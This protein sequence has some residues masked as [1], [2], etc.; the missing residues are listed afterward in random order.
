[1]KLHGS[2]IAVLCYFVTV[3]LLYLIGDVFNIPWLQFSK[4]SYV[5]NGSLER[6]AHSFIPFFLAIPVYI[7]VYFK[8]GRV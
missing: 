2:S 6:Q 8:T 5:Q 3:L 4:E 1:M 7:I